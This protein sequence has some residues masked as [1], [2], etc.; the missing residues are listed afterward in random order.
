MVKHANNPMSVELRQKYDELNQL[1]ITSLLGGEELQKMPFE[2]GSK[3]KKEKKDEGKRGREE[4]GPK[5][6]KEDWKMFPEEG[7]KEM[8]K[9]KKRLSIKFKDGSTAMNEPEDLVSSPVMKKMFSRISE[10]KDVMELQLRKIVERNGG[11]WNYKQF[12][13]IMKVLVKEHKYCGENCI[14]LRRFYERYGFLLK[15]PYR[16]RQELKVHKSK[17]NPFD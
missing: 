7:S 4:A 3:E 10:S 5:G 12:K 1:I 2:E 11:E 15:D 17:P 16:N 13:Q 9:A 8:N 6:K 14:H